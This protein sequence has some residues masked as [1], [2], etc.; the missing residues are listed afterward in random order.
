MRR[1]DLLAGG[2]GAS[3]ALVVSGGAFVAATETDLVL[4]RAE[5][6]DASNAQRTEIDWETVPIVYSIV[7][8]DESTLYLTFDDGP[9][10]EFTPRILDILGEANVKATFFMI[11]RMVDEHRDLARRVV[12]EGHRVAN[13][14]YDHPD[15]TFI[16]Q[17]E[18]VDQIVRTRQVILDVT[19]QT[20][21]WFRPPRGALTGATVLACGETSHQIAM[22]SVARGPDGVSDAATVSTHITN[23]WTGGRILDL[24]DGLGR[25]TWQ[26]GSEQRDLRARRNVEIDAL[27]TILQQQTSVTAL[28]DWR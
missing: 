27:P 19:G 24:H 20:T 9:N 26:R 16:S 15:F 18:A 25:A 11:G 2:I 8:T 3:A 13:H 22:W 4:S 21:T 17:H 6:R 14:S 23:N 5:A 7:Q 10:P 28:P 12:D 1:R